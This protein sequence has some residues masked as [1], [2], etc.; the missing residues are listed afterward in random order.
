M[1]TAE[2]VE[3]VGGDDSEKSG[4]RW[5]NGGMARVVAASVKDAAKVMAKLDRKE[6]H[7]KVRHLR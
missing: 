6:L 5:P 7:G 3:L 4:T 2:A 1:A